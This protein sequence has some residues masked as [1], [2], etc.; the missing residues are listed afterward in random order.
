MLPKQSG[1]REYRRYANPM[2]DTRILLDELAADGTYIAAIV[3][4]S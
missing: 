3:L 4:H 2:I 1:M